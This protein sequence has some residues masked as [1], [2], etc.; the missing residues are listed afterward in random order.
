ML[1][2]GGGVDLPY[3]RPLA[4]GSC[5]GRFYLPLTPPPPSIFLRLARI[6][7]MFLSTCYLF[8]HISLMVLRAICVIVLPF[9]LYLVISAKATIAQKVGSAHLRAKK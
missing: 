2:G 4:I 7:A 3:T 5:R 8:F 6:C 9:W 1:Q